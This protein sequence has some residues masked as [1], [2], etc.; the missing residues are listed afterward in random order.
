MSRN[1]TEVEECRILDINILKEACKKGFDSG[2]YRWWYMDKMDGKMCYSITMDSEEYGT[3]RL[4][5][6]IRNRYEEEYKNFDCPVEVVSSKCNYGGY[7]YWMI[8]PLVK[9]GVPCRNRVSKLYLSASSPY[10]GC[11]DCLELTYESKSKNYHDPLL[12]EL[13]HMFK[14]SELANQTKRLYYDGKLTR[15]ALKLARM[16][17]FIEGANSDNNDI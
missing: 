17:Y 9:R 12:K 10:F 16:G 8:C 11:R 3:L 2:E 15:K 14:Y 1:N 13:N 6:K 5:Y 4:S 7:R